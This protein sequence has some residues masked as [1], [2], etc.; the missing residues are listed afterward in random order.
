MSSLSWVLFLSLVT[1]LW[2]C[3]RLISDSPKESKQKQISQVSS[4][5][6]FLELISLAISSTI[7]H[8][9]KWKQQQQQSCLESQNQVS[10]CMFICYVFCITE[11]AFIQS[12]FKHCHHHHLSLN[13]DG[14]LGTTN[15]FTNHF[16]KF[17]P[18]FHCLLELGELQACP[19]HDIVF[20]PLPL[21]ALSSSPFH[22][23]LQNGCSHVSILFQFASLSDGQEVFVCSDCLL[24]LGTDF[25]V[26]SI[27]FVW[28]T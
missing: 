9:N 15:D 2:S 20:P 22:C 19:F 8:W 12:V 10:L 3:L 1:V 21:S 18:V 23:A 28:Y 26:G 5:L 16:P 13:C 24:D 17:F 25:L 27:A 11:Q 6:S 14:H 4:I 7:F